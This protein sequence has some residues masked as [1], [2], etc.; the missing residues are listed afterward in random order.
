[1]KL[2]KIDALKLARRR[3]SIGHRSRFRE[4]DLSA[5]APRFFDF[6]GAH[7]EVG[8]SVSNWFRLARYS[9]LSTPAAQGEARLMSL[10]GFG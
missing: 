10:I 9:L 4:E 2:G 7:Y 5:T 3:P 1:M 6:G 8:N